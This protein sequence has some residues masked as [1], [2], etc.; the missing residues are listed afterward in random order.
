MSVI[1]PSQT[2]E[3]FPSV[4]LLPGHHRVWRPP[5]LRCATG[6][7]T[8]LIAPL[9]ASSDWWTQLTRRIWC[10]ILRNRSSQSS[11][12]NS[13]EINNTR[14]SVYDYASHVTVNRVLTGRLARCIA[15]LGPSQ[16]LPDRI[17]TALWE[18]VIVWCSTRRAFQT[19]MSMDEWLVRFQLSRCNAFSCLGP[20]HWRLLFFAVGALC[21][22]AMR[23]Y[24]LAF[25]DSWEQVT[26]KRT[27]GS[28]R[29]TLKL[30]ELAIVPNL[31]RKLH[32]LILT[33]S[34]PKNSEQRNAIRKTWGNVSTYCTDCS[35][36]TQ[37]GHNDWKVIF[38]IG[39]KGVH[40]DSEVE[41]ESRKNGDI[42]IGEFEDSYQNLVLKTLT[43]FSWAVTVNCTYVLKADDDV[44]V[45]TPR[46]IKWLSNPKLPSRLYAGQVHARAEP[47]R[48]TNSKYFV[49]KKTYSQPR[50]PPYCGGPFY[51]LSRNVLG[52]ILDAA[53]G[54]APLH[55]EDAYM[56]I[57]ARSVGVSPVHIKEFR[58]YFPFGE[59]EFNEF[60]VCNFATFIA[61]GDQMS[62]T[63][64][65]DMHTKVKAVDLLIMDAGC[66]WE[67][68]HI[69]LIVSSIVWMFV[70]IMY[71]IWQIYMIQC[72][73]NTPH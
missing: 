7:W 20:R 27:V 10:V 48:R 1:L 46:L 68:L 28:A 43:G 62:A 12:S 51:I 40:A 47:V 25:V 14:R 11:H 54:F 31:P 8:T 59:R 55:I 44:Y 61:V 65:Q 19:F 39:R 24:V 70:L 9:R 21:L 69:P 64:I 23:W 30:P 36:G 45:H 33:P 52:G 37:H 22:L 72:K 41:N 34:A 35:E 67:A 60:S 4:R 42:L 13:T 5:Q 38:L 15:R 50:Y 17:N 57:L 6:P 32:L 63:S 73:T 3:L 29:D 71:S 2:A 53:R 56:G 16:S 49:S 58:F 66:F 18:S 26:N